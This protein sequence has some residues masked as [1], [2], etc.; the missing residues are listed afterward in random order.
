MGSGSYSCDARALRADASGYATASASD[1]RVFVQAKERKVNQGMDPRQ[2]D[3]RECRDNADHPNTFPIVLALDVTGSMGQIPVQLIREDLPKLM[4]ALLAIHPDIS[5]CF[6]AVGDHECDQG[7][8]QVGQFEASDE[9]LDHW[10]TH[11]W[12]EQGGGGNAGESY[13]LPWLFAINGIVTDAWEKRRQRGLL[14]TIGDEPVLPTYPRAGLKGTFGEKLAAITSSL[15]AMTKE[16]IHSVA[17]EKWEIFHV[18]M[19]AQDQSWAFL[20]DHF[21]QIPKSHHV[22]E[23][24]VRIVRQR[25]STVQQSG[26]E[27]TSTV[28]APAAPSTSE[29]LPA[30]L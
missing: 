24:I 2:I 6:M 9:L 19:R 22:V 5:L 23:A 3:L 18:G 28:S 17:S 27:Q 21:H 7:P 11:T 10:L 8:L 1:A 12:I 16:E 14:I 4:E 29:S 15:Q 13:A 30:P 20:G 25:M 26:N